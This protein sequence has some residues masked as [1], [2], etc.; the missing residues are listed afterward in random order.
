MKHIDYSDGAIERRIVR[1][2]QLRNLCLSLAKA[3][4]ANASR[5]PPVSDRP[6]SS[7]E[8]PDSRRSR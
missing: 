7:D 2:S 5:R 3:N 4:P 8:W 1:L 6:S